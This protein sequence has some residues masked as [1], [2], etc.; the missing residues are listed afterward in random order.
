MNQNISTHLKKLKQKT[1]K[2]HN[3]K[4]F[5]SKC[6][7]HLLNDWFVVTVVKIRVLNVNFTFSTRNVFSNKI[8][9]KETETFKTVVAAAVVVAKIKNIH[10]NTHTHMHSQTKRN[11]IFSLL[12]S[13]SCHEYVEFYLLGCECV[14]SYT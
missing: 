10:L 7:S 8:L 2:K 13:L 9:L 14:T 6:L 4:K 1:N 12:S 5:T 3:N 11:K